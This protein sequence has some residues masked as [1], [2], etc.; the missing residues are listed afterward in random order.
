MFLVSIA[1]LLSIWFS[2]RS[3]LDLWL[4]IVALAW[5]LSG[6]LLNLVGERFD[7]A[8]YANR[9]FAVAS[10]SFVLLVLVVESTMLYTR[11]VLSVMAR[12]TEREGRLL[13]MDALSAAIAH[14][15]GQPLTAI[16]SNA[17]AG[18]GWIK[19]SPPNL[20]KAQE[21]YDRI[22]SDTDRVGEVMQSV[23][24]MFASVERGRTLVDANEIIRETIALAW[25]ELEIGNIVVEL[26][27]SEP[28]PA[29]PANRG[30]IR[31]VLLN[32]VSNAIEAMGQTRDRPHILRIKSEAGEQNGIALFVEDNGV[33]VTPEN[34]GRIF[35]AFFTTRP[36]GMGIGLAVCRS[37]LEAHGGGLYIA[38]TGPRGS[39]FQI[40]LPG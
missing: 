8:W 25:G 34:A 29:V 39:V 23:R 3:V 15:I 20:E 24:D 38:R 19:K 1:A 17:G 30:Q 18:L 22:I 37:I 32:L 28:I 12:N 27:L 21:A 26:D 40:A 14:E 7:V 35:D 36:D 9:L 5:V 10:D 31:Q 33:G 4:V 6:I 2:Q 11:L 13:S 16:S